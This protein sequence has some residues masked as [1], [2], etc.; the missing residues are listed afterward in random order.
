MGR[1]TE[2][3]ARTSGA[4]SGTIPAGYV[5]EGVHVMTQRWNYNGD[6]N[7]EHGG[8]FWREDGADDYV[9]AVRVTPCSEAGGP[10]NLFH[11]EQGSVYLPNDSAKRNQAL[12]VIGQTLENATRRDLVESFV[13]YHGIDRDCRNG[14]Q[15]IQIGKPETDLR[16]DGWSPKPD[17][18][19]RGNASLAN[20]V[21]REILD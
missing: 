4:R 14:E 12:N 21:R 6:I 15:V 18:T 11:I 17:I 9:L 7:L 16:S 3:D 2:R 5:W 19:L 1:G 10:N 13:A 20:Y 8:L